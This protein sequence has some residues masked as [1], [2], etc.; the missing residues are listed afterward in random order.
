MSTL[1]WLMEGFR[2]RNASRFFGLGPGDKTPGDKTYRR[3]AR[4]IEAVGANPLSAFDPNSSV[5]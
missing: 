4:F 5:A 1:T 3:F 2:W